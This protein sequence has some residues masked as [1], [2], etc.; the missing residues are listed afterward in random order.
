MPE[1]YMLKSRWQN[2]WCSTSTVRSGVM[3]GR[4]LLPEDVCAAGCCLLLGGLVLRSGRK[5]L[6][7]SVVLGGGP[8]AA[9]AAAAPLA[10]AFS[11]AR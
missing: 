10:A 8:A 7:A 4:K 3:L 2:P 9:A 1:I 11:V 6:P 5:P